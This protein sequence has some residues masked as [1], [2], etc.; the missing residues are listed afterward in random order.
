MR[1]ASCD[2]ELPDD[3]II[4]P[5]CSG[6]TAGPPESDPGYRE[7]RRE[8]RTLRGW[9]IVS[10]VFGIFA[11][12]FAI[13]RASRDLVRFRGKAAEEDPIAYRQLRT[14]RVLAV[15]LLLFWTVILGAKLAGYSGLPGKTDAAVLDTV[16]TAVLI[17]CACPTETVFLGG[18]GVA[19]PQVYEQLATGRRTRPQDSWHE[20]YGGG[21]LVT[22]DA[23]VFSGDD[24]AEVTARLMTPREQKSFKVTYTLRRGAAG[25]WQ[26]THR[27]VAWK[28]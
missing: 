22:L 20:A 27:D 28:S 24:I 16:L 12:P 15:V 19:D 25:D 21:A 13:W 3:G 6:G 17:E 26:T 5:H 10:L 4:C 14:M 9:I 8:A 1:C 2:R 11:A 7:L 18:D 23:P